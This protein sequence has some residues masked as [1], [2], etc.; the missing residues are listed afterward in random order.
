MT[1]KK[2]ETK[3]TEAKAAEAKVDIKSAVEGTRELL[4]N[5]NEKVTEA[6]KAVSGIFQALTTS[7]RALFETTI[8]VDKALLG[9]ANDAVTGYAKLGRESINAKCV[10]DLIDLHVAYAHDR[11]EQNAANTREVLDLTQTKLKEAYAPVQT[12]LAPYFPQK[13]NAA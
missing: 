11:V 6:G 9:Y 5:T 1:N 12:V 13:K 2:P 7:S 4:E 8:A 10:N 3:A